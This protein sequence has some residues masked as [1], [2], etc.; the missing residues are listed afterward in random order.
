MMD[1]S[2]HQMRKVSPESI[3]FLL[4]ELSGNGLNKKINPY[5][6]PHK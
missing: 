2:S 6:E 3:F 4:V 1:S 5:K